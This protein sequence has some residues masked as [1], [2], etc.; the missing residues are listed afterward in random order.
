MDNNSNENHNKMAALVD[1]N[2]YATGLRYAAKVAL[3]GVLILLFTYFSPGV[4][5]A[6]VLQSD[7]SINAQIQAI[8][9]KTL[10]LNRDLFVLEEELLFPDNTQFAVFV[11]VDVG[12]FFALDSVK[13]TVNG[14]VV[15]HYLY[16]ARQLDALHKG[17]VHRLHL[18]NLKAG[19]HEVVAVF[20]GKGPQGRDYRR[21]TTLTVDKQ[22]GP[23]HLE[24]KIVDSEAMHQP[25]F[26]IK[27]W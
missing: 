11:S 5:A 17:G 21:A 1:T 25:T 27:E 6:D 18:G 20:T 3:C 4:S 8:K 26:A 16:T 13:L 12:H 7:Q 15:S 22:K 19:S 23:K 2:G 14:E 24:L 9:A 10:E